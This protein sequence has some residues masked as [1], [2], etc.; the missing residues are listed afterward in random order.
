MSGQSVPSV[1]TLPKFG[2][3]GL[4]H[5]L[6]EPYGR[7]RILMS[8]SSVNAID[9]HLAKFAPKQRRALEAVRAVL[10][11]ALPG[12]QEVI[13]WKMP[14]LR[15]DGDLVCSYDG[16]TH[17]N[18][19]FPSSTAVYR[20]LADALE[21]YP[22]SKGTIQFPVDTPLP[23]ALLRKIVRVRIAETNASYPRTSGVSKTFYDNGFLKSA[24][25]YR[26][27]QMH[28]AWRFYRKDGV[29]MRSGTFRDGQPVGEWV[30]YDRSGAPY[31]VTVK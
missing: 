11:G 22:T 13:A 14:S 4:T 8:P 20:E 24:G 5:R 15:I 31:R 27:D 29:L 6:R 26:G 23:A 18:S 16:F 7:A 12:A 9:A 17:H 2:T 1:G 28:G 3:M 30:T 10:V 21:R 19:L 25:K